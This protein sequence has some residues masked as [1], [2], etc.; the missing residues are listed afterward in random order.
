MLILL[1]SGGSMHQSVEH[2]VQGNWKEIKT[3]ILAIWD[4][5]TDNELE[6]SKGNL[7]RLADLIHERYGE[8]VKSI[9]NKME[10]F[11]QNYRP[12]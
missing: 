4:E 9:E 7:H 2:R 11:M 1:A 5:M 10:Q 8:S 3:E 12:Q 6:E